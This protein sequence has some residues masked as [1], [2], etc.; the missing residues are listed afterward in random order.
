[1]PASDLS[2]VIAASVLPPVAISMPK[3]FGSRSAILN[4]LPAPAH[5]MKMILSLIHIL[6][7]PFFDRRDMRKLVLPFVFQ[8]EPDN[9]TLEAAGALSSWFGGLAGYRGSDLSLIHI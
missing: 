7:L 4:G 9:A 5:R 1:M 8:A 3:R 2:G 6:P